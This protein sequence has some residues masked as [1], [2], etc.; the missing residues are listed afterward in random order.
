MILRRKP[1]RCLIVA[2]ELAPLSELRERWRNAGGSDPSYTTGLAEFVAPG[3]ARARA[4]GAAAA[5]RAPQVPKLVRED[6]PRGPRSAPASSGAREAHQDEARAAGGRPRYL[7]EIA[8]T[9]SPHRHRP[10]RHLIHVIYTQGYGEHLH[11]DRQRLGELFSL[12]QRYPVVFLP[13]HKSN[14]TTSSCSTRCT[15][16]ATRRTTPRA[17]S[18]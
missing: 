6:I 7:R 11:Y 14:S 18:T 10:H 16:T 15:R 9:H 17:A 2:G 5:R 8:A 4:R 1:E 13:S 3:G 12:T